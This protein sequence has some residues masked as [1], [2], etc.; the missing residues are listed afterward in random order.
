VQIDAN[1]LKGDARTQFDAHVETLFDPQTSG[2]LLGV[3]P[4]NAANRLVTTL[5]KDGQTA[6]IIGTLDFTNAGV[7]LT[8]NT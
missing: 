1:G 3:F 5:C 2:G 6:A 4:R 7:H 8:G